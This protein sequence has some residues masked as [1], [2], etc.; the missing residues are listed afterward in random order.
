[1]RNG[2]IVFIAMVALIGCAHLDINRK[3][4]ALSR[5]GIGDSQKDV[6]QSVGMPDLR[7]DITENRVVA[8]YQTQPK[9]SAGDPLTTELCT[10]VSFENGKVVA[11]G[12]DLTPQWNREVEAKKRQAEID[13]LKRQKAENARAARQQA[14]KARREKI[15]ALEKE[16]RPVPVSN[17]A[18]NLKLYRQLRELDPHNPRYQKKVAFY[19]KRLAMQEK[20]RQEQALRREKARQREAWE[21]SR[22]ARNVRLRQYSGNGT[23]EMAVHDMG[24]GSLY[25]WIKNVSS[26]IITTH[27]DYFTLIDENDDAVPCKISD[28]FDSVLEPGSISHGR[29]E[30]DKTVIPKALIFE[31]RETG[32]VSKTFE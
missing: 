32:R 30:Y 16:V 8:F 25:V 4:N 22:Q 2:A 5:I 23:A 1:M 19:E 21:N 20:S 9:R 18:L 12:E 15:K 27:P 17:A 7:H 26:Q 29:I 3:V 24:N 11:V 10:P 28:S 6:F 14:E 13:A 31:N